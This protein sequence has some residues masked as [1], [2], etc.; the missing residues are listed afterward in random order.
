MS[1][2]WV[3][4]RSKF[5]FEPTETYKFGLQLLRKYRGHIMEY[6]IVFEKRKSGKSKVKPIQALKDLLAIV[7]R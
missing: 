7:R 1:G 3:G 5:N 2:F 6:P 4:Y